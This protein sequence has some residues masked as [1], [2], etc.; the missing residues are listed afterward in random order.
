MWT[1]QHNIDNLYQPIEKCQTSTDRD[2]TVTDT[3]DDQSERWDLDVLT[4]WNHQNRKHL[5]YSFWF[6][7]V[8]TCQEGAGSSVLAPKNGIPDSPTGIFTDSCGHQS[9]YHRLRAHY[10]C[11]GKEID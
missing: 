8:M 4:N 11:R 3:S 1:F 2:D 6:P 10:S 5:L 9:L 7:R